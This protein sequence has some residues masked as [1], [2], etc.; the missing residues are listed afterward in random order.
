MPRRRLPRRAVPREVWDKTLF[1]ICSDH[2]GGDGRDW[3]GAFSGADMFAA[4]YLFNARHYP[5][6]RALDGAESGED[7]D[8]SLR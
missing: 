2:G 1:V 4:L 6:R 3:H 5:G 8:L 7:H